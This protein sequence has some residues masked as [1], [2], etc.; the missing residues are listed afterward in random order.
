MHLGPA[1]ALLYS[2]LALE[3][4]SAA[5]AIHLRINGRPNNQLQTR[6]NLN[7]SSPLSNSVDISYYSE[8]T[9]GGQAY[10]VL[11]DTGRCVP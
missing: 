8:I 6:G 9:L 11:I 1:S 3:S 7:G 4:A 10:T 5:H 2:L